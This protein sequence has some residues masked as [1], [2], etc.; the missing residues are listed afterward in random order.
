MCVLKFIE[1]RVK[2]LYFKMKWRRLNKHNFTSVKNIFP[3]DKGNI[4]IGKFSYGPLEVMTW[5]ADN[6]GLEI[7]N[8]VSIASGVKFVL[9]G[10]H[11]FDTISTYP[12][13]VKILG[14][15]TEA[16]SKGKITIGDDAWIGVDAIILSGV[17]IGKGAVIAAGSV[18]TKDV[19]PYAIAGGNPAAVIKFRFSEELISEIM[20]LDFTNID[21]GFIA[22]NRDLIYTKADYA[23][24]KKIKECLKTK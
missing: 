20:D 1:D 24:I 7:G 3:I 21:H 11:R 14:E 4:K 10:N 6:E 12:F 23:V 9:G 16:G 13:K 18:V 2:L 15:K 19:P 17:T 8:F 5:G 22:E